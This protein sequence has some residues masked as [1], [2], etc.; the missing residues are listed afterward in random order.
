MRPVKFEVKQEA[1]KEP[2]QKITFPSVD[3]F[4]FRAPGEPTVYHAR[5]D[6]LIVSWLAPY[7][8][9][10]T[11]RDTALKAWAKYREILAPEELH[12]VALRYINRLEFPQT[13]FQL[14]KFFTSPP[15]KPPELSRWTFL[16][17]Q[18]HS[19][20]A[21]PGSGYAVQVIFTR[22]DGSPETVAFI[23]DIEVRLKE[24]LSATARRVEEVL[25]E[26]RALKNEAFFGMLTLDAIKRY[27]EP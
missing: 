17:F 20:F 5:R 12:T 13:D 3:G 25:E 4:F 15:A 22:I 26:M 24:A 14:A 1:G 9:W 27:K 23:L 8:N 2:E 19:L 21:V 18:H 16:G 7:A 11:L 10:E 6:G